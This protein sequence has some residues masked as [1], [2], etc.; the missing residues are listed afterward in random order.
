MADSRHDGR[1]FSLRSL[2]G[3]PNSAPGM[4]VRSEGSRLLG[5]IE[6]RLAGAE[7]DGFAAARRLEM[8]RLGAKLEAESVGQG[9]GWRG[10]WGWLLAG[11]LLGAVSVAGWFLAA[12]GRPGPLQAG[13][14]LPGELS[15]LAEPPHS[16][17]SLFHL[18]D[19][20]LLGEHPADG[21][22]WSFPAGRYRLRVR[23][24]NCPDEWE[25]EIE[26][27]GGEPRRYAPELC[28]GQGEV[29]IESSPEDAR[30][31]ID[32]ID[33]GVAG[34]DAHVLRT[35]PHTI[36]VEK[37]GFTPW[38]GTLQVRAD[39]RLVVKAELAAAAGGSPPAPEAAPTASPG[40]PPAPSSPALAQAAD[41]DA[42]AQRRERTGKGG[43][44][45]WHDAVKHQLVG[46]YDRNGSLSLDLPAEISSIPCPVLQN[47]EASY[48]T[49]GL[50]VDMIHLYGFDGSVAPTNTLGVT[51]S[52]RGYAYE[53]MKACGL[54]T[55]R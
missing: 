13:I 28:Q 48:E 17:W 36:R 1:R 4:Q 55:R 21:A 9:R 40:P 35:G 7:D 5:H 33:L 44:K 45:S 38:E 30:L 53:R 12:Q 19:Q 42:S 15:V 24:P 46:D 29:V 10:R 3:L 37:P 47:V 20:H 26:L 14:D 43:S 32:G 54:R 39:E 34:P 25:Q 18:Q 8:Q 16:I 6:S 51:S 31:Q 41:E 49:G 22:T 50:T 52:M 11:F 2:L 23:N 27:P